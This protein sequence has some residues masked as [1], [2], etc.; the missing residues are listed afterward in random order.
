MGEVQI[1]RIT[2][3]SKENKNWQEDMSNTI[4]MLCRNG[5]IC[6][7]YYEDCG[8]YVVEYDYNK[9][10]WGGPQLIWIDPNKQTIVNV[11]EE[12]NYIDE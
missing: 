2:F 1:N 12:G 11:D 5:Y 4:T 9:S 7:A 3:D 6:R 8:F 10:E